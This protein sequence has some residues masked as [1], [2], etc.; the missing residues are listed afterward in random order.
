MS[1]LFSS[2][3]RPQSFCQDLDLWCGTLSN[4]VWKCNS[5]LFTARGQSQCLLL[6]AGG[7]WMNK[8]WHFLLGLHQ[9]QAVPDTKF[10]LEISKDIVWKGIIGLLSS[11][12]IV[13][14]K[15]SQSICQW[16]RKKTE[17][18]VPSI[19]PEWTMGVKKCFY[20]VFFSQLKLSVVKVL[21]IDQF[22]CFIL[23]EAW[24]TVNE[25]SV[26][27]EKHWLHFSSWYRFY[28]QTYVSYSN[29]LWDECNSL[30][31]SV[32]YI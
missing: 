22:D 24:W 32:I 13:Y 10:W 3:C 21:G 19:A 5:T 12:F 25:Y 16:L 26:F 20:L 7:F 8:H 4:A 29:L 15:T 6:K 11:D 31:Q 23:R 17:Q 27:L 28:E 18:S 30:E 2:F 1:I 14:N 9:T